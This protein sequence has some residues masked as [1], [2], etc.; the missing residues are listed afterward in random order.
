[1]KKIGIIL[2]ILQLVSFI[3]PI[4]RGDNIFANGLANLLGRCA[5]G[6]VGVVL[7][8]V[9]NKRNKNGKED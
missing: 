9:A 7:L 3:V 4:L 2:I 6:I 5:L 8:I 1:M